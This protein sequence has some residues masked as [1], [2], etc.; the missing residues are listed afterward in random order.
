M[1]NAHTVLLPLEQFWQ[2]FY[3]V[4]FTKSRP[5]KLHSW[6]KLFVAM[7]WAACKIRRGLWYA[8][9]KTQNFSNRN[10]FSHTSIRAHILVSHKWFYT[11]ALFNRDPSCRTALTHKP[12]YTYT[13]FSTHTQF[14]P[15]NLLKTQRFLFLDYGMFPYL[16][17]LT[18]TGLYRDAYKYTFSRTQA[19]TH[20]NVWPTQIFDTHNSFTNIFCHT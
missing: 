9:A 15:K 16:R 1:I 11:Q 18:H 13:H 7:L 3:L 10:P 4:L 19:F 2:F 17:A 6:W 14:Y 5:P 12:F 20:K 8:E